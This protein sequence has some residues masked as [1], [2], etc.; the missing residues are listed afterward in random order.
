MYLKKIFKQQEELTELHRRRSE[1]AQQ[2]V[3]LNQCLQEKD[4][5]LAALQNKLVLIY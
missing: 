4:N 3:E 2:L 1:S 5:Q